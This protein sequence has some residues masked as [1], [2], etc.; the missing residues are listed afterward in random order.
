MSGAKNKEKEKEKRKKALW[1][2]KS[3]RMGPGKEQVW[4]RERGTDCFG[5]WARDK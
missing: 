2:V 4:E 5:R 1:A 3:F